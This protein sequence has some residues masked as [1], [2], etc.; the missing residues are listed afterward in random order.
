M[1]YNITLD[2]IT[3]IIVLIA[4][5]TIGS[6]YQAYKD[7]KTIKPFFARVICGAFAGAVTMPVVFFL[8]LKGSPAV[9]HFGIATLLG[10]LSEK[11]EAGRIADL[12][13]LRGGR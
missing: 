3:Y 1:E 4:F 13:F 11:G 12:I 5:G 9:I 2:L 10:Y 6:C 8:Q 7:K